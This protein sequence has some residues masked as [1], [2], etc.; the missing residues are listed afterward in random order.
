MLKNLSIRELEEKDVTLIVDA[1][2]AANWDKPASLFEQYLNEVKLNKRSVWIAF[3]EAEFAGYITL[4]WNSLYP[5]FKALSIPEIMDMNVLPK[6]RRMG[7]GSML[8]DIAEKEANTKSDTV[9]IGVGLYA[10]TDGGYGAAQR[11]Y[12]TRGYVPDGKGIT[13]NYQP[14]IPGKSYTVDDDLVLWFTKKL[15]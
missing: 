15:G 6:Y 13:Y 9:G 3:I 2:K 12:V 14:V 4:N 11:I 1:F 10:G 5:S 8:L 7:V